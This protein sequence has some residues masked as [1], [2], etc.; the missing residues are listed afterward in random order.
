VEKGE[1]GVGGFESTKVVA[2]DS[3]KC[4]DGSSLGGVSS[5]GSRRTSNGGASWTRLAASEAAGRARRRESPKPTILKAIK[6]V[7]ARVGETKG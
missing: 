6:V 1:V 2:G 7:R 5:P 3:G 4:G